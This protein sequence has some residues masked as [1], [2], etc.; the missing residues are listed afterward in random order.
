MSK[1][2]LQQEHHISNGSNKST[3]SKKLSLFSSS[4][5]SSETTIGDLKM[6][7]ATKIKFKH[8][9]PI[10]SGA[11]I[12]SNTT[13]NSTLHSSHHSGHSHAHSHH[14][15]H[16]VVEP[17]VRF[18]SRILLYD[19]YTEDEYDRHP[20]SGTCNNLTPQL[21]VMIKNELNEVKAEMEVHELSRCYTHFF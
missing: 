14:S 7:E 15:K 21:A 16:V 12:T 8:H 5:K 18:S 19:T 6:Q 10:E 17:K 2:K 4:Q 11:T 20:E 1:S 3:K 13:T 9:V